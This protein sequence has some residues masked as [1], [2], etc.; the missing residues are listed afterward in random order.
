MAVHVY[1]N[2]YF[3]DVN[4]G[5]GPAKPDLEA[6]YLAAI[7][8]TDDPEQAYHLTQ[9]V[10]ADWYGHP[11]VT[12]VVRSR[13][14]S[15]GDVLE[16]EEGRLLLVASFGFRELTDRSLPARQTAL[17][18]SLRAR[19]AAAKGQQEGVLQAVHTLHTALLFAAPLLETF[20]ADIDRPDPHLALL[21][22]FAAE[23][24]RWALAR[25]HGGSP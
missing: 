2:P 15:I 16:T 10:H 12:T 19:A 20:A 23:Q 18:R 8:D 4:A 24:A 3:L 9:H 7:I 14:T 6:L 5:A 25:A 17:M 22:R 13:S 1:H 11:A 21:A